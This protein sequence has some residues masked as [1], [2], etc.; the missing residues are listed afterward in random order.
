MSE[1]L[2]AS[3]IIL[4]YA[5]RGNLSFIELRDN[6]GRRLQTVVEK[7]GTFAID[8]DR[9]WALEEAGAQPRFV[10]PKVIRSALTEAVTS[11]EKKM[12]PQVEL[13]VFLQV[14]FKSF[15][16]NS[17]QGI[18]GQI[19]DLLKI[20]SP[21]QNR[22]RP[23]L[24]AREKWKKRARPRLPMRILGFQAQNLL[25]VMSQHWWVNTP[26]VQS[27][28]LDLANCDTE[29][30]L[31]TFLQSKKRHILVCN[32]ANFEFLYPAVQSVHAA[33]RPRLLVAAGTAKEAGFID[34]KLPQLL[35]GISFC[36]LP[37]STQDVFIPSNMLRDAL[38]AIVHDLPLHEAFRQPALLMADPISNQ[39][40]RL[41]DF[42][43]AEIDEML[44]KPNAPTVKAVKKFVKR[45]GA[46]EKVK[47]T[48]V[49]LAGTLDGL[50]S[51]RR[52]FK[53]LSIDFEHEGTGLLPMSL[54]R[55][56]FLSQAPL[57]KLISTTVEHNHIKEHM[58]ANQQRRVDIGLRRCLRELSPRGNKSIAVQELFVT[59]QTCLKA[60][61]RYDLCLRIGRLLPRSILAESPT[62][63]DLVLPKPKSCKG[64]LL[65]V[66]LFTQDFTVLGEHSRKFRL[67]AIGPS[68]I[69]SF[70]IFAPY[71]PGSAQIRISIYYRDHM[72]QSFVLNAAVEKEERTDV[73]RRFVEVTIDYTRSEQIQD[74]EKLKP[75]NLNIGVNQSANGTHSF[76]VKRGN[77]KC[78]VSLPQDVLKTQ[79]NAF[80]DIL[81]T[82]TQHRNV[83]RQANSM[84]FQ[85][86]FRKLARQG[87]EL[88]GAL[89]DRHP[90]LENALEAVAKSEG[91]V[92]QFVRHDPNYAF[93]WSVIYDFELPDEIA[94][95]T[96]P[97][98]CLGSINGNPC[99]HQWTDRVFCIRGFWGVRHRVEQ[100]MFKQKAPAQLQ[101]KSQAT[102]L[103]AQGYTDE[104]TDKLKKDLSTSINQGLF[105]TLSGDLLGNVWDRKS[106][107]AM[108]VVIGHMETRIIPGESTGPRL[109]IVPGQ[110]WLRDIDVRSYKRRH[111][112]LGPP[113]PVILLLGCGTAAV[114]MQ[115]L[116]SL[117][118]S[119]INAGAAAVIGTE[120][121]VFTDLACQLAKDLTD[122]MINKDHNF[123]DAMR[124]FRSKLM[125]GGNPL[126]FV[127]TAFGDADLKYAG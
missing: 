119:L 126:G 25:S 1:R 44:E 53:E 30:E 69:V 29:T 3:W 93:P 28:G 79:I 61:G 21:I 114:E 4:R 50:V 75:R 120:C 51:A 88:W 71:D 89:Y 85:D 116:N 115:T 91:N 121:L 97:P 22:L 113:Q 107:P 111:K 62:P 106:G 41:A 73:K 7:N 110:Q 90:G 95:Q 87:A 57:M 94:G 109:V 63:I 17:W 125:E 32:A 103:F 77:I 66:V 9:N 105:K 104:H 26:E 108:V 72:L 48:L 36:L 80:R 40:L 39:N 33:N 86:T 18:Y 78:A 83:F 5:F 35:P 6:I 60:C 81:H 52:Q 92:L 38:Y 23:I 70:S 58:L 124:F 16:M 10:D 102:V 27:F 15:D 99:N 68:P 65:E 34:G 49:N 46:N 55:Q 96:D 2:T 122:L 98:I 64:H 59:P 19:I 117:F 8:R 45:T 13:P 112:A 118:T 43:A 123:G 76:F 100:L 101:T 37:S 54:A 84:E 82:A 12:I 56:N 67:P 127:F 74:V 11:I 31:E 42:F 47:K 20:K 14:N 24:L